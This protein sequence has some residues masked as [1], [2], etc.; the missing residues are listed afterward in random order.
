M[1]YSVNITEHLCLF[2]QFFS[3]IM[4]MGLIIMDCV[5]YNPVNDF[6]PIGNRGL[7]H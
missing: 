6:W 3:H 4:M 7:D 2:H 1:L 5:Q